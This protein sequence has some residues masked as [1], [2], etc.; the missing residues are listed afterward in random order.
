M[1]VHVLTKNTQ[2]FSVSRSLP[3]KT[4]YELDTLSRHIYTKIKWKQP[5]PEQKE[6]ENG[7]KNKCWASKNRDRANATKLC[8]TQKRFCNEWTVSL[9]GYSFCCCRAQWRKKRNN[10]KRITVVGTTECCLPSSD[11]ADIMRLLGVVASHPIRIA[12]HLHN[13]ISLSFSSRFPL[14][15]T[16]RYHTISL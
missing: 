3:D 10:Q 5:K 13:F 7:G 2:S 14:D 4:A 11:R 16:Y 15:T 6:N 1:S 9:N 8:N 12:L